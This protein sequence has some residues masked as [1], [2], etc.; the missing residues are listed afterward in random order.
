MYSIFGY[1]CTVYLA[2]LGR[3]CPGTQLHSNTNNTALVMNNT[4]KL[5]MQTSQK[6][7][8]ARSILQGLRAAKPMCYGDHAGYA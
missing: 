8:P 7:K 1:T 5:I 6:V 4:S 2:A 3:Q